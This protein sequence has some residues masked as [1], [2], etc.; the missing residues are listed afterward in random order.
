MLLPL[1]AESSLDEL[2]LGRTPLRSSSPSSPGFER[3]RLAESENSIQLVAPSSIRGMESFY[4]YGPPKGSVGRG[5][6]LLVLS[7][8]PIGATKHDTPS[9]KG[10]PRYR[11][12]RRRDTARGTPTMARSITASVVPNGWHAGESV[13]GASSGQPS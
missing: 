7:P 6:L 11:T 9:T 5:E 4:K 1:W 13:R 3:G 8:P 10:S 2:G 12:S